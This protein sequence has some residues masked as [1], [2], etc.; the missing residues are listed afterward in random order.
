[1]GGRGGRRG[2]GCLLTLPL[3]YPAGSAGGQSPAYLAFSLLL[4]P[5][6]PA[7]LPLR[8]RG[9]L[10]VILCKGLRPLHPR[11][12]THGS[13]RK[14]QEAG[15]YEQCRQPRRG[16][17]GGD[18]TI[19]RKRRRRLR[20]SSPPGQGEQV[21]PGGLLSL[22]PAYLA[23]VVP[24]GGLAFFVARLPFYF[25]LLSCPH[26]PDPLPLRGRG[27]LKVILCKGLRPL[28][29]RGCTRAALTNLTAQVPCEREPMARCKNNGNAF[30][31]AVPSAKE[32]GDR[33]RGTSA[34][35]MV[36]SPGAGR[37]S[38]AGVQPPL[39]TP[40]RQGK[41]VP[42][43]GKPPLRF[44]QRQGQP[45]PPEAKAHTATIFF[46]P[47]AVAAQGKPRRRRAERREQTE[48]YAGEH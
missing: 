39:R 7:P 6:P 8:G 43:G 11:G 37:A 31:M 29:P 14:R 16:G 36:L 48:Q 13:P 1:M 3:W 22:S 32:R 19:R 40:Q 34:F 46:L 4:C 17:T 2:F 20:W 47:P 10:K 28:H 18:G 45:V 24:S 41:Q 25:S 38:A 12:C 30:L 23:T 26:P 27:G 21:P 5:H 33:G 35:E 44:P 42:Q 15:P 9:G